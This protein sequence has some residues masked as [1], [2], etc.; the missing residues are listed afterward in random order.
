MLLLLLSLVALGSPLQMALPAPEDTCPSVPEV[1]VLPA[2]LEEFEATPEA[3]CEVSEGLVVPELAPY[4]NNSSPVSSL[5]LCQDSESFV[6]SVNPKDSK[7][8][9]S[10][11]DSESDDVIHQTSLK[12]AGFV[13][14]LI[15]F[16][17]AYSIVTT[18]FEVTFCFGYNPIPSIFQQYDTPEPLHK[19]REI[20][21]IPLPAR[22]NVRMI[23]VRTTEDESNC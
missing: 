21:M 20:Q 13:A 16:L 6:D 17:M 4:H 11:S 3:F 12:I 19:A 7:N 10:D 5:V 18:D 9:D 2:I 8:F 23:R 1:F 22:Q 14:Q 15:I